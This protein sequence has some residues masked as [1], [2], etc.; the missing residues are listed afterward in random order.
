M[1]ITQ[2]GHLELTG[3]ES[4]AT[5]TTTLCSHIHLITSD[6][7]HISLSNPRPLQLAIRLIDYHGHIYDPLVHSEEPPAADKPEQGEL[8]QQCNLKS[9]VSTGEGGG[10]VRL[11]G[12]LREEKGYTAV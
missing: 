8:G 6:W 4:L 11:R 10:R 5:A 12:C 9:C 1:L 2:W 3:A 7:W